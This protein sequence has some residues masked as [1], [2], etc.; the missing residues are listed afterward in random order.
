MRW[1]FSQITAQSHHLRM[2]KIRFLD[3]TTDDN[4]S[5][6]MEFCGEVATTSCTLNTLHFELIGSSQ[7][8]GEQFWS[9]LANDDEFTSLTHLTIEYE[10]SWFENESEECIAPLMIVLA[11][12]TALTSLYMGGHCEFQVNDLSRKQARRIRESALSANPECGITG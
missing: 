11:R 10:K 2:L 3:N 4:R 7:S 8:E 5:L 9:T 12:Q 1:P 6:I